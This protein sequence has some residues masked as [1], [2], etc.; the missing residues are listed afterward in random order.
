MIDLFDLYDE[1][2]GTVNTVQGGHVRPNRNFVKWCN[3]ISKEI[4]VEEFKAFETA[5]IISDE[6]GTFL[7][8]VNAIVTPMRGQMWD[9]V[10]LEAEYQY[11][12]SARIRLF[13][14]QCYADNELA[15]KAKD[16]I[17]QDERE[18]LILD[19][20]SN[21]EE[22]GITKKTNNRWEAITRRKTNKPSFDKPYC[23][24]FDGG[25][26]V[27]PKNIGVIILDY[28]RMPAEATFEYTVINEGLESE[29][30]QYNGSSSKPLEWPATLRAKFIA[31]LKQKYA[32]M[33]GDQGMYEQGSLE[34][35][36]A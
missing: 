14:N 19:A 11:F 13:Q 32:G 20:E 26:K 17:D 36:S 18:Q 28:F 12:A 22:I 21:I 1:F 30:I 33:T 7:K 27:A 29:Y 25:L 5:E 4:F 15:F 35:R 6:L 24:R 34:K 16:V 31:R 10:K 2:C 23:T 3:T 9:L 8:S